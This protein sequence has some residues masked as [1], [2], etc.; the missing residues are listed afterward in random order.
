MEPKSALFLPPKRLA[1]CIAA[2]ILRDTRGVSLK[3]TDRFNYFPATPLVSVT[4]V[5]SGELRFVRAMGDLNEAQSAEPMPHLT[6]T[7]PQDQP[8]ASWSPGEV[9]AL[10]IGF[11]PDAWVKLCAGIAEGT[12]PETLAASFKNFDA[13]SDPQSSW[14]SLCETLLPMWESKRISDGIPDWPGSDRLSDWTRFLFS[15]AAMTASARGMRTFE[16]RLKQW[17][18]STRQNLDRYAAIED[19]HRRT[20]KTPDVSLAELANDAGF[21]DQ[22]HMGRL[23]LRTTGFPPHKLNQMIQNEESFWCYRLLGE[24]F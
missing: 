2:A 14:D 16:R 22:S 17:T 9:H 8:T 24:R 10:T 21:S 7:Q 15:R 20:V 1:S 6:V 5:I 23:V 13:D 18:G 4:A 3:E 19:L 12:M 11:Y